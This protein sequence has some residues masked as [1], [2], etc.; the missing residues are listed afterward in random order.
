MSLCFLMYLVMVVFAQNSIPDSVLIPSYF[1]EL[2]LLFYT[3]E[4]TVPY[5]LKT[6]SPTFLFSPTVY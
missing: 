6:L 5:I 3:L 2:G 1:I 4:P